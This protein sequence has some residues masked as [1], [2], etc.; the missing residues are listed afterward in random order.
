MKSSELILNNDGSVYH[1]SLLPGEVAPLIITVGD[2]DRV[3]EVSKY[4]DDIELKKANREFVTHTGRIGNTRL[5]VISTGIGTDNVDIVIN[6]LHS[7]FHLNLNT[8]VKQEGKRLTFVRLGTSGAIRESIEVNTILASEGAL[9]MDG[10]LHFY[11]ND[12]PL[13][14]VVELLKENPTLMLLPKP[15]YAEA[16]RDLLKKFEGVYT[17]RGV[18][19]TAPGFYAPQGRAV[20]HNVMVPDFLEVLGKN[21]VNSCPITNLEMETA[22]I[23]GLSSIF[24]HKALSISAILANRITGKFSGNPKKVV[25][26]M[27]E[28]TLEKISELY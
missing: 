17:T 5:T 28:K 7:L 8:Q 10:L 13:F 15:Y 26:V 14:E 23:Y 6:E 16:D 1:L 20:N 25:E 19:V 2:Q 12:L 22:G 21:E 27:I 18:T 24:Q 11:E 9:G 4:F 3:R